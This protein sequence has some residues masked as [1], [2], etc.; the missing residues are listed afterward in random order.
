MG[1][2]EQF[3]KDTFAAE[4]GALT[5]GALAWQDPP[6]IRLLKVQADGMLLVRDPARLPELQPPWTSAVGH[7]EILLELKMAGDHLDDAAVER[8]LLRRQARQVERFEAAR[9]RD[10]KNSTQNPTAQRELPTLG[11]EPV[12]VAAPYVPDCLR[13]RYTVE[14]FAPGCYR[15]GPAAFS[16][17]WIASN[18][19]P[20]RDDLIPFL[21]TRSGKPL[22]DLALWT[23]SYRPPPWVL[24]MVQY[25]AMSEPA[26]EYVSR[27]KM[28]DTPEIQERQRQ[29]GRILMERYPDLQQ[30]LRLADARA[31][32]RR[33]LAVRGLTLRPA[34]DARI[35]ACTD[36][37]TLERWLDDAAVAKTAAQVF[38]KAA[39]KPR[40]AHRR[41]TR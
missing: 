6:E 24:D 17:L 36:V 15:V 31:H 18:E 29:L 2:P 1:Q 3:A 28:G 20:L 9:S 5:H 7:V 40:P 33:V 30:E 11:M 34:H 39:P 35:D 41:A 22:D 4:V 12:W 21:L 10:R 26:R 25:L 27:F 38:G 14:S 16:F 23:L 37:A 19:L 32:L 8:I 13:A